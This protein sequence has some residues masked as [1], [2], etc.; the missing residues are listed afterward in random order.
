MLFVFGVSIGA[1]HELMDNL[2]RYGTHAVILAL[3]GV[4]GSLLSSYLA[5]RIMYK[6]NRKKGGDR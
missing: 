1:N 6:K 3:F 4:A 5:C 2:G